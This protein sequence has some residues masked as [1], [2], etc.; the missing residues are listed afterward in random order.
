MISGDDDGDGIPDH[1]DNDDDGDGIS[2]EDEG[3]HYLFIWYLTLSLVEKGTILV[4]F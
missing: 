1:L 4:C 3:N 2:D